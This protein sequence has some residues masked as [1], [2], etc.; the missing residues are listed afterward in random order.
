MAEN[1]QQPPATTLVVFGISGDLSRRYILP[2]LANLKSAGYLPG[3]FR[4]IGLSRRSIQSKDILDAGTEILADC[5]ELI[6]MDMADPADYKKLKDGLNH[7]AQIIFYLS[8]P[9]PAVL[10]ILKHLSSVG[11]N[12]GQTKLLLEKP[13]GYDLE[14]ARELNDEIK[15]CFREE[16]VYRIDHY[17][18]KEMAQNIS[19]FLGSNALFRQVWNNQFIDSIEILATE[20]IGIEG[21]ANFYESTGALR[22]FLQSHLMNLAALALMRPCSSMSEFEE[23]PERRLEALQSLKP[24]DPGE[25]IR[26]QYSGY[27]REVGNKD[28]MVETFASVVVRSSDERWQGVPIRLTSGKQLDA[29]RT[30]IRVS[31]KKS[32]ATQANSLILKI[33]PEEGIEIDLWA[34]QPGFSSQLRH[35]PLSFSYAGGQRLPDAYERVLVDAIN[36]RSSLFASSAEVLETWRILDPVL[37]DWT[38]NKSSLN[39]YKSGATV[40]EVLAEQV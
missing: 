20:Q 6:R 25:S 1:N 12:H 28:S 4:L 18:A 16:Q 29:K 8:I 24:V 31:F 40:E 11:L 19:V 2:A 33:Q 37:K 22:D 36:S 38:M 34:K 13:F 39:I 5:L 21:R 14:S 17:M 9:P 35:L 15:Q 32:D 23:M 26:G 7:E 10:P 3:N 27:R 30:L